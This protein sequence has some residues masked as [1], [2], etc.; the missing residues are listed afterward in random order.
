MPEAS[1]PNVAIIG[2]GPAGLT[3]AYALSKKGIPVTLYEAAPEVGGLARTLE[4]WGQKVD[5]GPHRFFSTDSRVN[6]LWLE[7]AQ[8]NYSMV[9]R[10]TRIYY[11]RRFFH[12]P[13]Q[14]INALLNLGPVQSALCLLSYFFQRT[15]PPEINGTFE[16]W[17]VSRFGRKL[18]TIFF[19]HYSEKLWGI[20]CQELDADFA[21]QRIKKLSLWEAVI[22]AFGAAK[23]KHKTLVDQFAYPHS[24]TGYIYE[25]MAREIQAKGGRILTGT[26]IRRIVTDEHS[27]ATHIELPDG[28]LPEYTHII[29]TMPLTSM[30]LALPE[31]P[32]DVRQAAMGL[33]FRNTI[34]VY[35][36]IDGTDL[37]PDNW[38]YV[39]SPELTTGRITNFSNWG[40]HINQDRTKTIVCLEFWC[41]HTDEMWQWNDEKLIELAKKDLRTTGLAGS[42]PVTDGFVYRIPRCYPVYRRGYR[43]KVAIIEGYLSGIKGLQVIGRYGS[44]K[45]NNQ[46]HSIL[47]GLLA[48][49][50]VADGAQ[51]NLWDINTDYENY[52]ERS[53]IT[54]SGLQTSPA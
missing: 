28:S 19:K 14:P 22:N 20:S 10:L 5:I 50:N 3:A 7:I 52:Q 44:F 15:S 16:S 21:A 9:D 18:F 1:V 54:A 36:H 34:I 12:Y 6:L 46:D 51:H 8:G 49:E 43:E 45:Y 35:L 41:N 38:L 48:A 26:P 24:G 29:S 23:G 39:H 30:V 13:L 25:R 17:V 27:R 53:L 31:L 4:L 47:M 32:D 33:S 42:A 40:D 11:R 37:F 2:A